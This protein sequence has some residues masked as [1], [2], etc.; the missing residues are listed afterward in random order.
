[1]RNVEI[2]VHDNDQPAIVL[3]QLDPVTL[4]ADT[5]T[6]VL[7]GNATTGIVDFYS[8]Q[9]EIQPTASV[10]IGITP[11]DARV[12]L[13]STDVL[14]RF[15]GTNPVGNTPGAYHVTFSTTNWNVPVVI[16]VTAVDDSAPQDPH[17][18]MVRHHVTGGAA[19]YANATTGAAEQTLDVR[20][21]DNDSP[22]LLVQTPA[23]YVVQK[24]GNPPSCTLPGPAVPY[25][26]RLTQAPAPLTTVNVNLITDGQTDITPGG[27]VTS[28][29][30][31][32]PGPD[33]L[34]TGNITITGNVISRAAGSELGSFVAAGFAATQLITINGVAGTFT[35]QSVTDTT[36][37][38][39]TTIVAGPTTYNGTS[40]NRIVNHGLYTGA[41]TFAVDGSGHGTITRND[42]SSWLDDGFLEGQIF[43]IS[44]SPTLWKIQA[45]SGNHVQTLQVTAVGAI[46]LAN[47]SHTFT[48]WSARVS[49]DTTNWW[50]PVSV[51]VVAD[52]SFNVPADRANLR[53]F[54]KQ[55]HILS[56]IRG[57]LLVE[58]G[59]TSADRSLRAPVLLP[60][61]KN[62]KPFAIRVQPPEAQQ[63]DVLNIFD[64]DSQQNQTGVLSATALTGLSMGAE[65]DFASTAFG[66]PTSFP[67]GISF[68]SIVID[69]VTHAILT[70]ASLSTVEVVNVMLGQGNDNLT[71]TGS[72]TP[73]PDHDSQGNVTSVAV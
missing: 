28:L 55:P 45:L 26:I 4:A 52:V 43:K 68:G 44:G 25:T 35:I 60:G 5:Q 58:G 56:N 30:I 51:P 73:G 38:T 9:L 1:M 48:Q 27:R 14:G 57:P 34:F 29:A 6:L 10:T 15:G 70:N 59:T 46:G 18:T 66:E 3:T 71:V 41:V 12:S 40:V 36:I 67:G 53:S 50:I 47:G 39:T 23:D 54:P 69:P 19:E 65:L 17:D 63:V 72:V 13:S 32:A 7:E 24:C 21:Y 2:L 16:K 42:N 22:G 49:F 61:E 62:A 8:V 20:V 31:G 64:D 33:A 37:T 11:A